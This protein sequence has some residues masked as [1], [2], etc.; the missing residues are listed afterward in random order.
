[1]TTATLERGGTTVTLQLLGEGAGV[2]LVATDHGKPNAGPQSKGSINPR[3]SD[4]WSQ[5]ESYTLVARFHESTAYSDVIELVDLVKSHSAGADLVLNI[6]LPEFDT[7]MV[8]APAPEQDQALSVAYDVGGRN[9]VDCQLSLTRVNS[10][11]GDGGGQSAS[12][13]TA[14]GTGPITLTDGS[15]SVSFT[16]D[17]VVDRTV[18][19]PNSTLSRTTQQWPN[20]IDHRKV[21]FDQF[22]LGA[23]LK[24]DAVTAVSNLRD[25]VTTQ[26]G[27]TALTLD[28]NGIYGMG[29]F[30]VVPEGGQALRTVRPSAEEGVIIVPTL[31]LRRVLV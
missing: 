23:E 31:T 13:P 1:M 9:M 27:R 8:V 21:A 5:M 17:I 19:R 6:D 28:F 29:A 22:T 20:Y 7:D 18:G 4:Q 16:N 24:T 26:L 12:T 11:Q 2:P 15:V 3:W 14:S 30:D 10:T 25:M